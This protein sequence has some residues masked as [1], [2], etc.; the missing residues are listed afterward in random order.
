MDGVRRWVEREDLLKAFHEIRGHLCSGEGL[1]D[2]E[3]SEQSS[4]VDP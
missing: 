2:D 1:L 4:Q 3:A